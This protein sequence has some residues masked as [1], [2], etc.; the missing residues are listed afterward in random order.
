[1]AFYRER[2]YKKHLSGP[3][4]RDFKFE[5]TFDEEIRLELIVT[6]RTVGRNLSLT[7]NDGTLFLIDT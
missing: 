4:Q 3:R 6:H 5:L 1:M 7:L 2:Y